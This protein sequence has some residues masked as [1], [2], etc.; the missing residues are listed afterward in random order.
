LSGCQSN[1]TNPVFSSITAC[2]SCTGR[3]SATQSLVTTGWLTTH[4]TIKIH[5]E[6]NSPRGKRKK[7]KKFFLNKIKICENVPNKMNTALE[8]SHT[9]DKNNSQTEI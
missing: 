8:T 2:K 3:G 4:T 9:I 7:D 6:T 5:I 1:F